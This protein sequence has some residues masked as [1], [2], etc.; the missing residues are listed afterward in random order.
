MSMKISKVTESIEIEK[1][2]KNI[3]STWWLWL[4][5]KE[6]KELVTTVYR[7]HFTIVLQ[8]SKETVNFAH[9]YTNIIP[10]KKELQ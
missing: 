9:Q 2:S 6:F 7:V 10:I 5:K 4:L 8:S 3:E 1:E